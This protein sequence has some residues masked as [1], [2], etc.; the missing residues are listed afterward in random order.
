MNRILL[1]ACLL[2]SLAASSQANNNFYI[3]GDAFFYFEVDQ[4]EW[5]EFKS[6][7]K[8]I[9]KYDRPDTLPQMFCGYAGYLNLDMSD[10]P[11]G[12]RKRLVDAIARM[13]SRYP[14]KIVEQEV[15]NGFGGP[16]QKKQ[17]ET[18]QIPVFVYNQN[19]D[20]A[21]YRIG[22]KYNESW[23]ATATLFG[24]TQKHFQFDFFVNTPKAITESWRMGSKVDSLHVALPQATKGAVDTPI[25]FAPDD[26]VVL[27]APPVPVASLCFPARET[28]LECIVVS[29]Q[30]SQTLILDQ[31]RWKPQK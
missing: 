30:A 14:T 15:P 6:G 27:V 31:G 12:Y 19:F 5:Q 21:N 22:L 7:K 1:A 4:S 8:S 24:H 9:W 18:N 26:L 17:Q 28:K 25:S 16:P 29:K 11:D 20:F 23:P 3:P 2:L 10:L 13:K